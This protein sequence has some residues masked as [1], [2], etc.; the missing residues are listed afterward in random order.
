MRV[1]VQQH[2]S[3]E[4]YGREVHEYYVLEFRGGE[5]AEVRLL[6]YEADD[7]GIIRH[8]DEHKVVERVYDA[9]EFHEHVP[10]SVIDEAHAMLTNA[11]EDL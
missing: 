2:L 6:V 5:L 10:C 4:V 3:S 8:D 9:D 11:A 7:H 1:E